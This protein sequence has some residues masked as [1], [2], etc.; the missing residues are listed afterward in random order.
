V[1]Y[2][3][4]APDI[5]SD[6]D[7]EAAGWCAARVYELLLKVSALKDLRGR[8][9]RQ[10]QAP[11]WLA[12]RW[13]LTAAD[14]PGVQPEDLIANGLGRLATIGLVHQDGEDLVVTGWDKFYRPAKTSAERMAEK[15][16][17]QRYGSDE[18]DAQPSRVTKAKVETSRDAS[19]DTSHHPLH[20]TP[21]TPHHVDIAAAPP[22]SVHVPSV[23]EKPEK[24]DEAWG[25]DDFT[26]WANAK[27]F[28]EGLP[29]DKK[30][31]VR[32]VSAWWSAVLMA[33]F[34]PKDVRTGFIEFGNNDYWLP[35]KL[36]IAGFVS[37]W[38]RFVV[39]TEV[40]HAG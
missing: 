21:P 23:P 20:N 14:L 32:E 1:E 9:P 6:P 7:I 18:S 12:K 35:R 15:R 25:S 28:E 17:R 27:R 19:D 10:F 38:D 36:P 39:K 2:L 33:G 11:A 31:N 16:L 4:L 37:Q 5:D 29:P 24:P 26:A 22:K 30:F 8:L 40:R 34:T 13:N 3:K